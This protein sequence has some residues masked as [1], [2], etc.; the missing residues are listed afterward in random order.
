MIIISIPQALL[1]HLK[2]ATRAT[3][4]WLST[5]NRQRELTMNT[6]E[7]ILLRVIIKL[8]INVSSVR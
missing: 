4:G 5:L 7:F 2:E 6:N 1:I 8:I 3:G